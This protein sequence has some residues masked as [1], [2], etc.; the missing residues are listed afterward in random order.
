MENTCHTVVLLT[1]LNKTD[2]NRIVLVCIQLNRHS[3]ISDYTADVA[4]MYIC[5]P[6]VVAT[7]TNNKYQN[8]VTVWCINKRCLMRWLTILHLSHRWPFQTMSSSGDQTVSPFGDNRNRLMELGVS[9]G[10]V[11]QFAG[12]TRWGGVTKGNDIRLFKCW[13]VTPVA[14]DYSS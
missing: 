3:W 1:F 9:E 6:R 13:V 7:Y 4:L 2:F 8:T 12:V 10:V 11:L 14:F 5:S